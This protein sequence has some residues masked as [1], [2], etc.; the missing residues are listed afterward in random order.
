MPKLAKLRTERAA[1]EIAMRGVERAVAE[2]MIRAFERND[3]AFA[4]GKHG[5]F[6][7]GFN[8]FKAGVAENDFAG[9]A[10][11]SVN[12]ARDCLAI[13]RSKVM[14]LNSRASSALRACGCTSPI[15]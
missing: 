3:P 4:G 10:L 13:Q 5:G 9:G 6:E 2:S 8:G 15:A 12:S 7:R 1:E 14:R 11:Q